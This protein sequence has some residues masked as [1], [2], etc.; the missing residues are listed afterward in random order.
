[1][2]SLRR[3]HIDQDEAVIVLTFFRVFYL[4]QLIT[5]GARKA[6]LDKVYGA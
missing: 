6:A 1:M 4:L 2:N 3:D 5:K